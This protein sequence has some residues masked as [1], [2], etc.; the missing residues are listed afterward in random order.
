MPNVKARNESGSVWLEPEPDPGT[1]PEP[2]LK[3]LFSCLTRT[4]PELNFQ[5]DQVWFGQPE[6]FG[7]F[8]V[9]ILGYPNRT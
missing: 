9:S 4:W 7:V 8:G 3:Y 2:E 5:I 1:R 6:I